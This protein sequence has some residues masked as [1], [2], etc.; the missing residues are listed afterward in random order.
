[1]KDMYTIG[2][3]SF[4]IE[5]FIDVLKKYK[6]T[7]L[8][9]VRSNPY[10]KFYVDF[11]KENLQNILRRKGI[12]YR[13]YKFEFGA[14]QEDLQY[15]TDGYLDFAKYTKSKSF[16]EGVE[17]IEAGIKMGYTFV[18]MCAEKDPSTCHRS[19]MVAREFYNSG[20]VIKNILS[21]SSYELQDD[22]EQRL[23]DE[24]F[25][26]RNQISFF[27]E[28]LSWEEMVHRSYKCRNS[29]IGYR[30]DDLYRVDLL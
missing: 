10:S 30:L 26:D 19:I 23:V 2:Y 28:N 13:N 4:K 9:D 12:I 6:I 11:N 27:P 22:I 14:Q 3:S 1:M 7:C 20:Y 21:D 17:K 16:I 5:E 25:P 8:I 18:L 24:F 15:H 29:E